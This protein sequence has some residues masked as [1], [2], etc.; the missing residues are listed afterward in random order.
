MVDIL[1]TIKC[2]KRIEIYF[3]YKTPNK[4]INYFSENFQ[5]III[6]RICETTELLVKFSST[7]QFAKINFDLTS[8]ISD[9]IS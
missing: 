1:P 4:F 6:R 9:D 3:K 8:L 2:S 5:I 7:T